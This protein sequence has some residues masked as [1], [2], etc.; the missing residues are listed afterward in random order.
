MEEVIELCIFYPFSELN[1]KVGY[2]SNVTYYFSILYRRQFTGGE[3]RAG[4]DAEEA[5]WFE[6]SS[7][8]LLAF[9]STSHIL[10]NY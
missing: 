8:P 3:L 10:D 5:A 4:D 2:V 1:L 9:K 7:L 6:R